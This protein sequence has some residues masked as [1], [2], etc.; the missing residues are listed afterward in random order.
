[1]ERHQSSSS[2]G[3]SVGDTQD[4]NAD[5]YSFCNEPEYLSLPVHEPRRS[6][7]DFSTESDFTS[8]YSISTHSD[9]GMPTFNVVE[10]TDSDGGSTTCSGYV[11][12]V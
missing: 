5:N 9:G 4:V 12:L 3:T 7:S 8:C 11:I 1:M 2:R 6:S 10:A